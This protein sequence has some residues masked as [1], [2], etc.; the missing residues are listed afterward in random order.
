MSKSIEGIPESFTREQYLSFFRAA[1]VEPRVI[2]TLRFLPDGVEAVVFA[3]DEQGKRTYVP[4]HEC[5]CKDEGEETDPLCV[6]QHG[7]AKHTVF[8]PVRG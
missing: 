6:A 3:V 7:F 5:T 4:D 1:G 2:K 8:I